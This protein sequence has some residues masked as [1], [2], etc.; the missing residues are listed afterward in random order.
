MGKVRLA[1]VIRLDE[2]RTRAERQARWDRQDQELER[3]WRQIPYPSCDW[4]GNRRVR[5]PSLDEIET[6]WGR[7]QEG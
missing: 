2:Y 3:Y 5:R 6:G 7:S 4:D 1:P